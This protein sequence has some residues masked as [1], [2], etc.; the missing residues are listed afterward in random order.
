VTKLFL[1]A[2][3]SAG[4]NVALCAIAMLLSQSSP[5]QAQSDVGTVENNAADKITLVS[6]NSPPLPGDRLMVIRRKAGDDRNIIV[7]PED[8]T[9]ADLAV[10]LGS[11]ANARVRDSDVLPDAEQR[12]G[13]TS[14]GITG[15]L[16][17]HQQRLENMLDKLQRAKPRPVPGLGT[18]RAVEVSIH[19]VP[20]AKH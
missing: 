11:L 3:Q 12:I 10:A 1:R 6:T 15:S 18:V 17:E 8:A 9:A 7:L 13:I 20:V 19:I 14:G 16:G 4:L 2:F 5:S